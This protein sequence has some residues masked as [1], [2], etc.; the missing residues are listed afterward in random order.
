MLTEYIKF[1][2][3][4][5]SEFKKKI[6]VTLYNG[7]KDKQKSIDINVNISA[8]SVEEIHEII[9]SVYND[10][11]SFYYLKATSIS[12]ATMLNGYRI[13]PEYIYSNEQIKEF[14]RQLEI[15]LQTFCKKYVQ[16]DMSDYQ[17]EIIIHDFLVKTIKYDY[18]A[19]N[20]I[21]PQINEA[22]NVLGALLKRR[23]V[24]WG[25]ACA[26]KLLCDYCKV[27]S[28]VVI[29]DTK[30]KQGA[31][32]HAWNMVKLDGES[33]HVDVTWDIKEKGD[34]SFC[35]DYLNLDDGLI[36]FDHSWESTLYPKC[37]SNRYN[38]YYLNRLYVKSV[39]KLTEYIT[40]KLNLGEKYIA[41]KFA[42]T[43]PTKSEIENAIKL[44]FSNSVV[45]GRYTFYISDK[46]H[47]IYIEVL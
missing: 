9:T 39:G 10:T 26:F 47:N 18:E 20:S 30:P 5:L 40:Q 42:N 35:Y 2:Y 12:I 8:I 41:I 32:G 11:P 34:I 38:Y 29:G 19:A 25:I 46:T 24:C 7:F 15:G 21:I 17:K 43:M 4:A 16:Q 13:F 3:G 23:A 22:Y 27:K 31:A 14:D 33:Y 6:Y 37:T 45:W 1:Y 28:F 36:K 44:S